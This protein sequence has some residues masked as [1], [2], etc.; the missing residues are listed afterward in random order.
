MTA[1]SP[2][3]ANAPAL[4]AEP[5]WRSRDW[6]RVFFVGGALLVPLP[7]VLFYAFRGAGL[8]AGASE[9]LVTL[10]VMV[11]L[12]GPHVAATFSRT[13]CNPEFWRRERGLAAASLLL[14]AAVSTTAVASAFFDVRVAG[15]PPMAFVLT[16]F[17]FWAGLH[18][19]Q[20]H[21]YVAA[22]LADRDPRARR[23]R[24]GW[25]DH[26]V[27]LLAL[28]PVSLFRMSMAARTDSGAVVADPDALAT[29]VVRELGA[30]AQFADEYV[31]CIG[32]A[33]PILPDFMMHAALWLLVTAAFVACLVL[34]AWK[35]LR[36]R[37]RG[38]PFGTR[39]RLV[40]AMAAC[41]VLVPLVP[42]LDSSFQGINAWHCF[43]YLGLAML[44]NREAIA[45][46][47]LKAPRLV[48]L[49]QPGRGLRAYALAVGA[50]LVLVGIILGA[51]F[52]L[53][54]TSGGRFV[55]FGHDV[56]P[57]D[58]ETGRV[59]Y[60]PGSVLLAYY[61]FGFGFLLI[62]YL[63][64]TVFFLRRRRAGVTR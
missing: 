15:W 6:D 13:L 30:S 47:E 10:L 59:L 20:Q 19:V 43:Q 5:V 18:V 42:N 9:D 52:V 29:R 62:H 14:L 16:G 17:F 38:V 4:A 3:L 61:L 2:L 45:R 58:P 35:A 55:M 49:A 50:T 32:R 28:Y 40:L 64:D 46:G 31:F 21:C 34:F 44:I 51:A 39:G 7:V 56:P 25:V 41:G 23:D 37:A 53:Q 26:A 54:A 24:A 63:Q 36:A 57:A 27:M 22:S 48:A 11:P 8:P 60:R 12:G 33:S 1:S